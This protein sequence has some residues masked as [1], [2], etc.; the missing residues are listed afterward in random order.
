MLSILVVGAGELGRA[1]LKGLAVS[2]KRLPDVKITVLLRS[3]TISSLDQTKKQELDDNKSMGVHTVC[4]DFI[5]AQIVDLA[6]IFQPFDVVIQC[7]GY[8]MPRGTQIKVTK[9]ALQAGV[10][11]YLPWQF[12]LD[13]DEIPE[14]SYG[15]M[16][17]DNKLVRKMLRE[18]SE[19]DWTVIST[20]LFMS[21]L[22][23]P[24]FGVVDAKNRVVRAL[25]SWENKTTITL[26]DDIGKMV[27]EVV[28]TPSTDHMVF[29]SG[30][31]ISYHTLADMLES[32]FGVN[33]QREL[34]D[35]PMLSRELSEDAGNLWKRYRVVFG[36]GNGV[37]WEKEKSINFQRHI[38]LTTVGS[39]LRENAI[40]IESL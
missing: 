18:Q 4:G 24:P 15:G 23:L 36:I 3:E 26:P 40:Q 31:T 29:L 21:Y 33:F 12:G 9:A 35:T 30:D 14:G 16:F 10:R 8:G 34:W 28:Y 19:I 5:A 39:Y 27:A 7:A 37:Y 22:F 11:R 38:P 13:F 1:V 6:A 20:G 2:P 32:H 25:G 17:D